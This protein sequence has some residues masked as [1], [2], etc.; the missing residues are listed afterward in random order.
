MESIFITF[1]VDIPG[2]LDISQLLT[3][4]IR[5]VHSSVIPF[6]GEPRETSRN[7]PDN[8]F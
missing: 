2:K 8:E 3:N 5:K 1:M 4:K 6:L 7:A